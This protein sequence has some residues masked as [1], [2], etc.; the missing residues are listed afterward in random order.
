MALYA[1]IILGICLIRWE[2]LISYDVSSENA[3]RKNDLLAQS[4]TADRFYRP[5]TFLLCIAFAL[6]AL[7]GCG[8]KDNSGHSIQTTELTTAAA[9]Q[10][11]TTPTAESTVTSNTTASETIPSEDLIAAENA[12]YSYYKNTVFQVNP[13]KL[14]TVMRISWNLPLMPRKTEKNV[15]PAPLKCRKKKE[16][17]KRKDGTQRFLCRDCR[18]SFIPSSDSILSRTRK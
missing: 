2:G 4:K 18:R 11:T 3:C 15:H 12:A 17:G 7:T 9:T 16:N 8:D 6:T 5:V 1:N 13:W 14:I 10:T